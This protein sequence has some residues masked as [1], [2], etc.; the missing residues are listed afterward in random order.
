MPNQ[1]EV[2]PIITVG[3]LGENNDLN[4]YVIPLTECTLAAV[5]PVT[6]DERIEDPRFFVVDYHQLAEDCVKEYEKE[7][8]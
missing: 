1:K 6:Q 3:G 2:K 4:V 7:K 8:E 5:V